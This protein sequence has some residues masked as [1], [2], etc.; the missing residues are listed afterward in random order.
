MA[1]IEIFVSSWSEAN[2]VLQKMS[3]V[4]QRSL[5]LHAQ[6]MKM[7][8]SRIVCARVCRWSSSSA[9][10]QRDAVCENFGQVIATFLFRFPCSRGSSSS[11]WL[12]L[13]W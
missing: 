9:N 12:S 2:V 8:K 10:S 11:G 6:K 7:R 1:N 4:K 13:V 3:A 5:I